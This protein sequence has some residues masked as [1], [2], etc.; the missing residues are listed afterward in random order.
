MIDKRIIYVIDNWK[1]KIN[2]DTKAF[3]ALSI[4]FDQFVINQGTKYMGLGSLK[5][6]LPKYSP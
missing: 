5:V 1:F 3:E 4:N 6:R 2:L